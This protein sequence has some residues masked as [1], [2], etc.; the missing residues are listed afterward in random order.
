MVNGSDDS[1][2]KR[3]KLASFTKSPICSLGTLLVILVNLRYYLINLHHRVCV[4]MVVDSQII[5]VQLRYQKCRYSMKRGWNLAKKIVTVTFADPLKYVDERNPREVNA[6]VFGVVNRIIDQ[7]CRGKRRHD[8]P[9]L[10]IN[11]DE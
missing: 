7:G 5:A 3:I 4:P 2:S 8:L 10:R 6:L 1:I 9:G 11:D